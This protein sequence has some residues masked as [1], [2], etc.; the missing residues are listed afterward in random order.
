MVTQIPGHPSG[1]PSGAEA[2]SGGSTVYWDERGG[3]YLPICGGLATVAGDHAV[4]VC[5]TG[6]VYVDWRHLLTW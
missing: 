3:M 2:A 5:E 6:V 1:T 4:S